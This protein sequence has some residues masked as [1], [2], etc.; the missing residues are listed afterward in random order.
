MVPSVWSQVPG[1]LSLSA[2]TMTC[3]VS[4]TN[5][6]RIPALLSLFQSLSRPLH[7]QAM[8]PCPGC[9]THTYEPLQR[10]L[11]S[12]LKHSCPKHST[13]S[14]HTSA[15]LPLQAILYREGKKLSLLPPSL[16]CLSAFQCRDGVIVAMVL[17]KGLAK[18]A[19]SEFWNHSLERALL[20]RPLNLIIWKMVD[21]PRIVHSQQ[22]LSDT[23]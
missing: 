6:I 17:A 16:L 15:R 21:F 2:V 4:T 8:P 23:T 12:W 10:P 7:S 18:F 1:R 9:S 3:Q 14:Q 11:H 22:D 19:F 5:C 13:P 20:T